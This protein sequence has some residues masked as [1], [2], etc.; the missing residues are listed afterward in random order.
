ML[1][2]LKCDLHRCVLILIHYYTTGI[3]TY[4]AL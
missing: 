4:A 2:D 3:F 1:Y